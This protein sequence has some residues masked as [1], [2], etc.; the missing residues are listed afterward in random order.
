MSAIKAGFDCERLSVGPR[1]VATVTLCTGYACVYNWDQGGN[2]KSSAI[3][4]QSIFD[5][6]EEVRGLTDAHTIIAAPRTQAS[7]KLVDTQSVTTN[8]RFF[9]SFRRSTI[10]F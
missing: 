7:R 4:C 3:L 5:L 10:L 1:L 2:N 9:L 8:L 6:Q